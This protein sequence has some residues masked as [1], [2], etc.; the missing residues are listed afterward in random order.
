MRGR[1]RPSV[2]PAT[3]DLESCL[4][5]WD[6]AYA[7]RFNAGETYFLPSLSTE[8]DCAGLQWALPNSPAGNLNGL[9][10]GDNYARFTP[11][12]SGTY[13][14]E[15]Q[16][17]GESVG[18]SQTLEV[19]NPLLRPFHNY[20]YFPAPSVATLVGSELWVAGVYSPEI[21]RLDPATGS[22]ADAITVGQW[23]VSLAYVATFN[24]VLVA[25][26]AS[27][28]VGI[29]DV[30]A[31]RQ[32]DAIWV[33]DEPTE[34]VWDDA[35]ELAYVSLGAA[36]QVAIVDVAARSLVKTLDAVFDPSAM[37]ISPDG[38]QL[39]VASHRSGQSNM[40]PY[41]DRGAETELDIAI[42]D[43]ESQEVD[44]FILEVSS[45]I[46]DLLFDAEGTLWVSATGNQTEG[47]L[48]NPDDRSFEHEI[49]SLVPVP[50]WRHVVWRLTSPDKRQALVQLET[51]KGSPCVG[52]PFGSSQKVRIN[53]SSSTVTSPKNLE[54]KSKGDRVRFCA[55]QVVRHGLSHP[56][57][58]WFTKS[59]T[60]LL[61]L[62]TSV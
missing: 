16:R 37:A 52:L 14:F 5:R 20:N 43:L 1:R 45:T 4:T 54:L 18:V 57:A 55:H 47:S 13:T 12:T 29:I 19:V 58:A 32:I 34:I 61:W 35:R 53:W 50:V 21:A 30:A 36:G 31:G 26:K 51:F 62:T 49:F 59:S 28:T 56:I 27:D 33:G 6:A 22:L 15:V 44:G 41:E 8:E 60:G 17:D 42:I 9:V 39:F 40:F 10:Q 46:H 25:N 2:E 11:H 7:A 38:T 48:N 23:P 24:E 3:F